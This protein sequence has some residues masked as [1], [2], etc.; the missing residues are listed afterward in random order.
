M[1]CAYSF[2]LKSGHS[3]TTAICKWGGS[4]MNTGCVACNSRQRIS[5]RWLFFTPLLIIV[6]GAAYRDCKTKPWNY[7]GDGTAVHAPH[8]A[9]IPDATSPEALAPYVSP[10]LVEHSTEACMCTCNVFHTRKFKF[11]LCTTPQPVITLLLGQL[12][13]RT[14]ST[15]Q[16]AF[17]DIR[18]QVNC[19]Q[20]LKVDG[21]VATALKRCGSPCVSV[22][23]TEAFVTP[24]WARQNV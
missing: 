7:L 19:S 1:F 16:C 23:K 3:D 8:Q 17:A 18:V 20:P 21:H 2:P 10:G 22:F 6:W 4:K 5:V 11:S 9:R 13:S 15:R 14:S 24:C 12:Q